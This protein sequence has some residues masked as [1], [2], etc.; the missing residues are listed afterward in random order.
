LRRGQAHRLPARYIG[1]MRLVLGLLKGGVIGGALGFA[2]FKLGVAG[3]VPAFVAYAI[4]GA[5]VGMVCGK[6]PWKQDTFWTSALKGIGGLIVGALLYWGGSKLLGGLHVTLP[7]AL[8]AQPDRSF[9]ELPILLGPLVG[10]L[11]GAFIEVDDGGSA[12][13]DKTK[14]KPA[15]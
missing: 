9:A 5:L 8:G 1:T 4:I 10:A 14:A 2:A 7:A 15:A 11:W 6:P 12:A 13:A 3:G